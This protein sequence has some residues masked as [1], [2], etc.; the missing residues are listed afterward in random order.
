MLLVA[1][2]EGGLLMSNR[3]SWAVCWPS[4]PQARGIRAFPSRLL[5]VL[6]AAVYMAGG[7]CQY[8][9]CSARGLLFMQGAQGE[10][11][12]GPGLHVIANLS[13]SMFSV[14][15]ETEFQ[16]IFDLVSVG[17]LPSF[18]ILALSGGR[19]IFRQQGRKAFNETLVVEVYTD[20]AKDGHIT[21]RTN[22]P[23]SCPRC[24]TCTTARHTQQT[25]ETPPGLASFRVR[26]PPLARRASPRPH[27]RHPGPQKC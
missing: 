11:P 5:E 1:V 9:L 21:A 3:G 10:F 15:T 6:R 4:V 27:P 18:L 8:Q 7:V 2:G 24:W 20:V 22:G 14:L 17:F 26:P 23:A 25:K 12:R 16:L 13:K 19:C